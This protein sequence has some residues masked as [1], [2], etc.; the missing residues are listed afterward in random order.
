MITAYSHNKKFHFMNSGSL[1]SVLYITG[2]VVS[3]A[4]VPEP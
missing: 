3:L 4:P 1:G 2:I